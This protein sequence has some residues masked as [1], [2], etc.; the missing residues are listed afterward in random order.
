ML[1]KIELDDFYLDDDLDLEPELKAYIKREVVFEIWKK[2]SAKV[3]EAVTA[4]VQAQVEQQ[5]AVRIEA[6]IDQCV[7]NGEITRNREKVKITEHVQN[8]FMNN[9]RWDNVNDHVKKLAHG[10][11]D[12]L[13]K[14][15]DAVFANRLVV[16]INEQGMLKEDVARML[17][18]G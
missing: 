14:R 15:Y 16:K 18:E 6:I 5:M 8:A 2:I 4:I 9:Y 12:D 17:L 3:D 11:A 1:F 7:Q 10:F 13:K